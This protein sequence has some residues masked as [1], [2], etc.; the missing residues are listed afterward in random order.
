MT[1]PNSKTAPQVGR[2]EKV[3][4]HS[5]ASPHLGMIPSSPEACTDGQGGG[6][7]E[8]TREQ[9]D[10]D[11]PSDSTFRGSP[12]DETIDDTR[13]SS[14]TSK[15]QQQGVAV[16]DDSLLRD[17][18]QALLILSSSAERNAPF[19][20]I[21][22]DGEIDAS[23]LANVLPILCREGVYRREDWLSL[24]PQ[25]QQM[26]LGTLR[27]EAHLSLVNLQRIKRILDVAE[28]P[29]MQTENLPDVVE[30]SRECGAEDDGSFVEDELPMAEPPTRITKTKFFF[31]FSVRRHP[32]DNLIPVHIRLRWF[33]A[34]ADASVKSP[35]RLR[36]AL[37]AK[38]E[39]YV[40][41]SSLILSSVVSFFPGEIVLDYAIDGFVWLLV[42]AIFF[43]SLFV[44]GIHLIS[45]TQ[46]SAIPDD[47]LILWVKANMRIFAIGG[48]AV[49]A[50]LVG[51][52]SL[53]GCLIW[54]FVVL[55][56]EEVPLAI[57]YLPGA[58]FFVM[59]PFFLTTLIFHVNVGS[60]SILET[61]CLENRAIVTVEDLR[62]MHPSEAADILFKRAYD[63]PQKKRRERVAQF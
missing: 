42:E 59:M 3:T 44:L 52:I 55:A 46:I 21:V 6:G 36:N 18:E 19:P 16:L 32:M 53:V 10:A 61:G 47:N 48:K 17:L 50:T 57:R 11:S 58:A 23:P 49:V 14:E 27:E 8:A 5:L 34:I 63:D 37:M 45:L 62:G 35:H 43:S 40:I 12:T 7:A 1:D 31:D 22:G 13:D 28:D 26:L 30:S 60:R 51:M 4:A 2:G 24:E 38:C 20:S 56:N 29:V 41:F 9:G 15:Q 39:M 33:K 25:F 54:R